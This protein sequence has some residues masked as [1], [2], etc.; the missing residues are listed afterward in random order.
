MAV[1]QPTAAHDLILKQL[2]KDV[3]PLRGNLPPPVLLL[4]VEP[5]LQTG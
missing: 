2:V 5:P 3:G 1:E 4:D